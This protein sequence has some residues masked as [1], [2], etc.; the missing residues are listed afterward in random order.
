[1]NHDILPGYKQAKDAEEPQNAYKSRDFIEL[2]KFLRR[3]CFVSQTYFSI[4]ELF[5]NFKERRVVLLDCSIEL[6]WFCEFPNSLKS[7]QKYGN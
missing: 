4:L 7:Y 5:R 6:F 1:M 3:Q 2:K